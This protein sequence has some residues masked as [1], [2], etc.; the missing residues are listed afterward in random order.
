MPVDA[1]AALDALRSQSVMIL[2]DVADARTLE[3]YGNAHGC[4]I[5]ASD[6]SLLRKLFRALSALDGA[7]WTR[8][9]TKDGAV[10]YRRSSDDGASRA[11]QVLGI[12]ETAAGPD[13]IFRFFSDASAFDARFRTLDDMFKG[14]DVL[15]YR[16]YDDMRELGG[17]AGGAVAEEGAARGTRRRLLERFSRDAAPR[18]GELF[19]RLD[20][21]ARVNV[22]SGS[23][24]A[25]AGRG[26]RRTAR[27]VLED[28]PR[29][30]VDGADANNPL[31]CRPG[32]AILR[33]A[34]RL[35]SVIRDRD[36]VW[37]QLTMKLPNGAVV[38]AA[39][40][41]ESG[42]VDA[43]APPLEGHVRGKILVSGYYAAPNP[44]TGGSTLYYV[45]Q[46]DPKGQLP[47][48]V[49]NL[50]APDQA[51]NVARLRNYLDGASP[52]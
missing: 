33:G 6:V 30:R 23:V 51:Q 25:G 13:E 28:V 40:S 29:A 32:H 52:R 3:T 36:F 47:M 43:V 44:A 37:E 22:E 46:A 39:Q 20:R 49:V 8:A 50:V 12:A 7:P 45:V 27:E 42:V 9:G 31:G 19:E 2:R 21:A 24:S 18:F 26:E 10:V 16:L 38:V 15:S 11:H 4:E 14:G 35:P 41:V 17:V 34:F 1:D 5:N 48:W